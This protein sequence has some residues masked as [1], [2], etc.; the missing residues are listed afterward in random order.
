MGW[1]EW[2]VVG[3][4]S[5]IIILIWMMTELA[6]TRL[7]E[8]GIALAQQATL[9]IVTTTNELGSTIGRVADG[10]HRI[11]Q[12][13]CDGRDFQADIPERPLITLI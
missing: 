11:E 6:V 1:F 8:E 2:I 5:V 10:L 12:T 7:R 13:V 9:A 4:L 3:Q